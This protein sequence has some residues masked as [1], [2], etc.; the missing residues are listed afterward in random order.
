M[1]KPIIRKAIE[2]ILSGV[3]IISCI[4]AD[5]DEVIIYDRAK[6]TVT[7]EPSSEVYSSIENYLSVSIGEADIVLHPGESATLSVNPVNNRVTQ[8]MKFNYYNGEDRLIQAGDIIEGEIEITADTMSMVLNEHDFN[9]VDCDSVGLLH[10]SITGLHPI[11]YTTGNDNYQYLFTNDTVLYT[12]AFINGVYFTVFSSE[13][14]YENTEFLV[15]ASLPCFFCVLKW[16]Y[17]NETG[18]YDPMILFH[19]ELIETDFCKVAD[20]VY[21]GQ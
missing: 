15:D 7:Y 12:S 11:N 9:I 18:S 10:Y 17:N 14:I 4:N 13:Y 19:H 20:F 5:N 21:A 2:L 1:I 16:P 3:L 6:I 8:R